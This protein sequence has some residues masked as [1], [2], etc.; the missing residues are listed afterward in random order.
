MM[1]KR[2]KLFVALGLAIGALGAVTTPAL[3]VVTDRGVSESSL[4]SGMY[5][6]GGWNNSHH[7]Q[8]NG[9]WTLIA[10][11][12][13]KLHPTANFEYIS[14]DENEDFFHIPNFLQIGDVNPDDDDAPPYGAAII[15][16]GAEDAYGN[17]ITTNCRGKGHSTVTSNDARTGKLVWRSKPWQNHD[18]DGK[19]PGAGVC[20]AGVLLLDERQIPGDKSSPLIRQHAWVADN[21][22][23]WD[24][25]AQTG[26]VLGTV[27][28]AGQTDAKLPGLAMQQ[29][30]TSG[31]VGTVT[32][33]GYNIWVDPVSHAVVINQEP[34]P[35]HSTMC[36]L[37]AFL[38]LNINAGEFNLLSTG[39]FACTGVGVNDATPQAN[40]P[41]VLA[42]VPGVPGREFDRVFVTYAAFPDDPIED[43]TALAFDIDPVAKQA[44]VAFRTAIVGSNPSG[45]SPTISPDMKTVWFST[46]AGL[47]NVDPITGEA[48]EAGGSSNTIASPA[49][50]DAGNLITCDWLGEAAVHSTTPDGVEN[51]SH[52]YN[53]LGPKKGDDENTE[54]APTRYS[55]PFV[56]DGEPKGQCMTI[57]TVT[58]DAVQ[59]QVMIGYPW[60]FGKFVG[61]ITNGIG[62]QIPYKA[63]N[64]F[65][66]VKTG[67]VM[68]GQ[69][70]TKDAE[71]LGTSE[72][73][74]MPSKTGRT[75]TSQWGVAQQMYYY[76]LSAGLLPFSPTNGI[77]PAGY[78][79]EKPILGITIHEPENYVPG[80]AAQLK[81]ALGYVANAK[82]WYTGTDATDA[83]TPA[84]WHPAPGDDQMEEAA[85]RMGYARHLLRVFFKSQSE[86]AV[87]MGDLSA[88]TQSLAMD[89]ATIAVDALAEARAAMLANSPNAPT[90]TSAVGPALKTAEDAINAAMALLPNA[91]APVPVPPPAV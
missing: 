74:V 59:E 32:A 64:V 21:T 57:S 62:E 69:D 53:D 41:A 68:P 4:L 61:N 7:D 43:D 75:H 12:P 44:K 42:A 5:D 50:D 45:A 51:W 79:I 89:Q 81:A 23:W 73:G 25:D 76:Q 46:V 88:Q 70:L 15:F 24:L 52:S 82:A 10:S 83:S 48:T 6:E 31:L 65:L 18:D 85:A 66:D 91:A 29:L 30:P 54:L 3:G 72:S 14:W 58:S 26:E 20:S 22:T 8:R 87:A 47:F 9:D 55:I 1:F 19:A 36:F 60:A 84:T 17:V 67:D 63:I 16:M 35:F 90:D 38:V 71:Y 11:T 34:E 78:D 77:V 56:L 28:I 37:P 39:T 49:T 13:G 40:V 33:D 27:D 2:N 80:V 86:E